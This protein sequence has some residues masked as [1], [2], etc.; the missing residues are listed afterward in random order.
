ML[1]LLHAERIFYA[2]TG[3]LN[4][5]SYYAEKTWLDLTYHL[6]VFLFGFVDLPYFSGLV[7]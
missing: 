2:S 1:I 5:C 4:F 7:V 6:H 3:S